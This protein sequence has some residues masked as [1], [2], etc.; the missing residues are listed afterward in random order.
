MGHGDSGKGF[1]NSGMVFPFVLVSTQIG[2]SKVI[3]SALSRGVFFI[4]V[5]ICIAVLR[6]KSSL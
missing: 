6:F 4:L 2:C 1:L 3:F 5:I